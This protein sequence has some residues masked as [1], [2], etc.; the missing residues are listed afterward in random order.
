MYRRI[1]TMDPEVIDGSDPELTT[2][3]GNGMDYPMLKTY[4]VGIN[5]TF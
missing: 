5:V 4:T 3:A 2:G 1:R